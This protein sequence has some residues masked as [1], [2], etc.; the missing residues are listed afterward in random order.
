MCADPA[1]ECTRTRARRV[2]L[3]YSIQSVSIAAV[4]V[5]LRFKTIRISSIYTVYNCETVTTRIR[6]TKAENK[7]SKILYFQFVKRVSIYLTIFGNY[8]LKTRIRKKSN[9]IDGDKCAGWSLYIVN[10]ANRSARRAY[11]RQNYKTLRGVHLLYPQSN[12]PK[13]RVH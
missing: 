1:R 12:Y 8:D 9:F 4:S 6:P 3:R 10:T 5:V 7:D 11:D 13:H 2:V